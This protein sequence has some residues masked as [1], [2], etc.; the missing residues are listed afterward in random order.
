MD[1][2]FE[3]AEYGNAIDFHNFTRIYDDLDHL[4]HMVSNYTE[5]VFNEYYNDVYLRYVVIS[6]HTR[7]NSSHRVWVEL[8]KKFMETFRSNMFDFFHLE[9]LW[10]DLD[11]LELASR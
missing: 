8:D 2:K 3:D 11:N 7:L 9:E 10:F 6:E 1:L 5:D 4:E